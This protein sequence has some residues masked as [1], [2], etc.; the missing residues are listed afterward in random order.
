MPDV[1]ERLGQE[2]AATGREVSLGPGFPDDVSGR[3][4]RRQRRRRAL[5]LS[6][7]IVF[8]VVGAGAVI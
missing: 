6:S 7:M 4:A 1:D 2:L 8:L 5:V 3:V